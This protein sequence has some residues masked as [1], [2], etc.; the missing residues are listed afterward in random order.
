MVVPSSELANIVYISSPNLQ[1]PQHHV[2]DSTMDINMEDTGGCSLSSSQNSSRESSTHSDALSMNYVEKLQ[3]QVNKPSWAKQVDVESPDSPILSYA[4]IREKETVSANQAPASTPMHTPHASDSFNT[5]VLHSEDS[6]NTFPPQG[7][8]PS[9]ISYSINQPMDPQLWDGNFCSVSLF[10]TN[11]YLK[12]DL[13]NI[14][15]LLLRN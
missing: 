13:K 4:T 12:G 3:A 8:E 10:G 11:E 5:N 7:M 2:T 15:C 1:I 6:N 14:V 9:V